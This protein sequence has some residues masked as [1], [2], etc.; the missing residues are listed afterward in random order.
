M[1]VVVSLVEV[2]VSVVVPLVVLVVK[3]PNSETVNVIVPEVLEVT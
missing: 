2:A 1:N 3:V